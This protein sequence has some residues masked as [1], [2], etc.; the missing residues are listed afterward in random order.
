MGE[1]HKGRGESLLS[2]MG[3]LQTPVEGS[4]WSWRGAVEDRAPV[5][6]ASLRKC[7]GAFQC[8]ALGSQQG[9]GWEASLRAANAKGAF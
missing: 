1:I 7:G 4:N 6:K 9:L 2:S 8:I 5:L 3:Q